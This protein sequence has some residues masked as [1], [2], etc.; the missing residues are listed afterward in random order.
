MTTHA[1]LVREAA[2]WLRGSRKCSLVA[3]EIATMIDEKPDAIGW[4]NQ[5][6]ILVECK[7]S[8]QDFLA[9]AKKPHRFREGVGQERWFYMP[10]GIVVPD[11]LPEGW[12]L[13]ERQSIGMSDLYQC[14]RTVK[15][16]IRELTPDVCRKERQMLIALAWR[17]LQAATLVKPL[18]VTDEAPTEAQ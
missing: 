18:S 10:A 2:N 4:G 5:V 17:A 7:T 3:T 12:G 6:S 13:L 15:P 14:R 16:E 11:D 9:D 8:R 1:Q